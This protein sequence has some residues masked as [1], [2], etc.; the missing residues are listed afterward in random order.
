MTLD[1]NSVLKKGENNKQKKL[2]LT[3]VQTSVSKEREVGECERAR[4]KLLF[5]ETGRSG[6]WRLRRKQGALGVG[7]VY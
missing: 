5:L 6:D 4:S 2:P 1:K 3:I 7:R